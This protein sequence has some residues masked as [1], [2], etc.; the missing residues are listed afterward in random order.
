VSN[1][2][3][4]VTLSVDIK[5]STSDLISVVNATKLRYESTKCYDVNTPSCISLPIVSYEI[6]PKIILKME[7]HEK[8]FDTIF[9]LFPVSVKILAFTL[10]PISPILKPKAH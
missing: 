9:S 5:Y 10:R 3:Y 7:F 2:N 4:N 8:I 6:Y 1:K